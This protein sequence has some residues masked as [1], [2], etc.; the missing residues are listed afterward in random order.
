MPKAFFSHFL[1]KPFNKICSLFI[2]FGFGSPKGIEM[3]YDAPSGT[4][5]TSVIFTELNSVNINSSGP[6]EKLN[7]NFN[8]Y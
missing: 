1:I 7:W 3:I 5:V 6:Y 4:T 8:K 2:Q